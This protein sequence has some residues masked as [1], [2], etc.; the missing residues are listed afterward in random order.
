MPGFL[1]QT[2]D[3]G[4]RARQ[5]R[6]RKRESVRDRAQLEMKDSVGNKT[7]YLTCEINQ[8]GDQDVAN[9]VVPKMCIFSINLPM[10]FQVMTSRKFCILRQKSMSVTNALAY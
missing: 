5:Q 8:R 2:E 6:D 7:D 9:D 3:A 1:Y 4:E 10:T